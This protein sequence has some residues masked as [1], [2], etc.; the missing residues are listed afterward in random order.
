[1]GGGNKVIGGIE[2]TVASEAFDNV[3]VKYKCRKV[4][5]ANLADYDPTIGVTHPS[6]S[7]HVMYSGNGRIGG[8]EEA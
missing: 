6:V 4:M 8:I 3:Q 1:M 7:S 2:E 5:W